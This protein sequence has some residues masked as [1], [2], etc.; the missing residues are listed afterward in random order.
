[1]LKMRESCRIPYFFFKWHFL[2]VLRG[3]YTTGLDTTA[4]A[5]GYLSGV[6]SVLKCNAFFFSPNQS[7]FTLNVFYFTSIVRNNIAPL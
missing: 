6:K 1:M 7:Q 5:I 2:T 4:W 3:S